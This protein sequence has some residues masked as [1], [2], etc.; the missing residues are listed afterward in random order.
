MIIDSSIS[1]IKKYK[2]YSKEDIEKLRY[3]MEG[4]YLTFTKFVVILALSIILGIFK[5][6]MFTLIFF[7][8]IR[9]TGF[10]FHAEKSSQCLV[11]SLIYFILLPYIFIKIKFSTLFLFIICGLSIISFILFAPADTKKRPLPN[12]KK[13]MIRK[14]FTV[15]IGIIYSCFIIIFQNSFISPLILV[16]LIIEAVI[17][18][19]V[20]YKLF[21]QPYNNYKNYHKVLNT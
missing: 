2:K 15:A 7:N 16:A 1:F 8:I 9:Y 11:L 12:K 10:G 3:G 20:F 6:V 14:I 19:P 21:K 4:I 5:E 17:I 18:Q 13:R